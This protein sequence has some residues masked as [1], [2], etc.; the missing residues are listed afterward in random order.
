MLYRSFVFVFCWNRINCYWKGRELGKCVP[1]IIAAQ[2]RLIQKRAWEGKKERRRNWMKKGDWTGKWCIGISTYSIQVVFAGGHVLGTEFRGMALNDLF[3]ADVLRPL[4]LVPLTDFTYSTTLAV[5][6][7]WRPRSYTLYF[8]LPS[9]SPMPSIYH[10]LLFSV[11]PVPLLFLPVHLP[12]S[13]SV[14]SLAVSL[15]LDF[16]C[17]K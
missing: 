2:N 9:T 5:C 6:A 12:P 10:F 13:S 17:Q 14:P 1:P 16:S 3:C 8:L 15:L 11:T 7:T 4:D